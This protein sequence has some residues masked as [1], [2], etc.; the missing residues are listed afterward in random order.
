MKRA[1]LT[2]YAP[3]QDV[4]STINDWKGN[5]AYFL[6]SNGQPLVSTFEGPANA[7]D[8]HAIKDQTKSFFI[9]DWSS[10][11]ARKAVSRGDGVADGLFNWGAW[12][13]GKQRTN[14]DL[15]ASYLIFLNNTRTY[16]A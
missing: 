6:H 3:T 13:E 16:M 11:G 14:W 2:N 4:V 8:W 15:D 10:L 9:P 7:N 5:P 12:P 1:A